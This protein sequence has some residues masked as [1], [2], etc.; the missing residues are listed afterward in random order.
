MVKNVTGGKRSKCIAR[1]NTTTVSDSRT[2][3]SE[4]ELE[5]Y[6]KATK[7]L[8]NGM[9]HIL[10][11]D[12]K[13]KLL[14]LRG[15]FSGKHKRGNIVTVGAYLL[16]GLRDFE[17]PNYTNCDLLEIY[18]DS[19]VKAIRRLPKIQSSFF[20]ASS[21]GEEGESGGGGGGKKEEDEIV[22]SNDIPIVDDIKSDNNIITVTTED[23]TE[24]IN[25]DDI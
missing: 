10:T 22:F 16:V 3:L 21:I 5:I 15:K 8:G 11:M 23:F 24:E 4:D 6:A 14:H 17:A 18:S 2:R 1:K 20:I 7:S 25:F 12:G 13:T 9:F 19:D